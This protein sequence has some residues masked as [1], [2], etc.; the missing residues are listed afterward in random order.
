ML[1]PQVIRKEAA[2]Y[3]MPPPV[4]A[5]DS[6]WSAVAWI[7]TNTAVP[8]TA[9]IAVGYKHFTTAAPE[10]EAVPGQYLEPQEDMVSNKTTTTH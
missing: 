4:E 9:K 5:C 6:S 1:V 2:K 3:G 10:A 7:P 8:K